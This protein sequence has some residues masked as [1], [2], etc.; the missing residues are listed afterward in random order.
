MTDVF[1]LC[2]SGEIRLKKGALVLYN[3][4]SE[5]FLKYSAFTGY[6]C[7]QYFGRTTSKE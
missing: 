2:L 1:S 7:L 3:I 4:H 6:Y 5:E